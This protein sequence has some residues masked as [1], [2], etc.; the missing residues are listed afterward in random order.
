MKL[1]L[2]TATFFLCTSGCGEVGKLLPHQH[3]SLNIRNEIKKTLVHDNSSSD[4]INDEINESDLIQ[5]T[6]QLSEYIFTNKTT[7]EEKK[8]ITH[9]IVNL[10]LDKIQRSLAEDNSSIVFYEN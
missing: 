6:V 10:K 2:L 9:I 8:L 5:D 4:S 7:P 1:S 3:T